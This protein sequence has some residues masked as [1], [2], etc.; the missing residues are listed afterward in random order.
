MRVAFFQLITTAPDGTE[1]VGE[2]QAILLDEADTTLPGML[3]G[4]LLDRLNA[5]TSGDTVTYRASVWDLSN[6]PTP[7]GG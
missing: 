2:S 5:Q 4:L 6:P 7:P 1:G 3:G